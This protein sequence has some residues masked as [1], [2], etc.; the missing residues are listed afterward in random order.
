MNRAIYG[1]GWDGDVVIQAA[2]TCSKR[3]G[4]SESSL[5]DA[6]AEGVE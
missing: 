6:G 5:V 2:T 3:T 1:T 4:C